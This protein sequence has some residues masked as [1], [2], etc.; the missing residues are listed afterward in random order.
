MSPIGICPSAGHELSD[1]AEMVIGLTIGCTIVSLAA[2]ILVGC[3][4]A[5]W[6]QPEVTP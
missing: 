5:W 6:R 2:L 3:W 4:L 1:R